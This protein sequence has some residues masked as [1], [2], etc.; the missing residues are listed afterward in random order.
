MFVGV[1]D[2]GVPAVVAATNNAVNLGD[3]KTGEKGITI[4]I[5]VAGGMK[6]APLCEFVRCPHLFGRI[7]VIDVSGMQIVREAS[8]SDKKGD[9]KKHKEDSDR[10]HLAECMSL[11][12]KIDF[13]F[14]VFHQFGFH[15]VSVK[16]LGSYVGLHITVLLFEVKAEN[17]F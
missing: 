3:H 15:A 5:V 10:F 11:C 6:V 12:I 4:Q 8:G 7:G 13:A 9:D 17:D 1:S 2:M 16:C 14:V